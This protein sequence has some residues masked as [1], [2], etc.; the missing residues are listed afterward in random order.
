MVKSRDK[1]EIMVLIV[2]LASRLQARADAFF[3]SYGVSSA[4]YNVLVL[5]KGSQDG[6]SQ[7]QISRQ[8][9]VSRANITSIIDKLEKKG[10]VKRLPDTSDRR[11]FRVRLTD[12]GRALIKEIEKAY[13][14]RVDE[15]FPDRLFGKFKGMR[16]YLDEWIRR[17]EEKR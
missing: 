11:S 15:I 9:V 2:R 17:L 5:L 8:M 1:N 7:V 16:R 3:R 6:L 10:L 13:F 14:P 4:Q 12:K